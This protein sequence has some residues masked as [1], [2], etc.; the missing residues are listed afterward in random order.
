MIS[1]ATD[2]D[3]CAWFCRRPTAS[4]KGGAWCSWSMTN[5][6]LLFF[7]TCGLTMWC[8]SIVALMAMKSAVHVY[9]IEHPNNTK[10][11]CGASTGD[12]CWDG[13]GFLHLNIVDYLNARLALLGLG[14]LP[15]VA[16]AAWRV[17]GWCEHNTFSYQEA[18]N[19]I[20]EYKKSE[21]GKQYHHHTK[22]KE[23]TG[24]P[25]F[26]YCGMGFQTVAGISIFNLLAVFALV[27]DIVAMKQWN[28]ADCKKAVNDLEQPWF[29]PEMHIDWSQLPVILFCT[30]LL[31]M[32]MGIFTC[33][34]GFSH[35]CDFMTRQAKRLDREGNEKGR[36]ES[37]HGHATHHQSNMQ[38]SS[39]QPSAPPGD[40]VTGAAQFSYNYAIP[41][42]GARMFPSQHQYQ[43]VP[44]Y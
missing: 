19:K 12:T 30:N 11:F 24:E 18:V 14:I 2:N 13:S 25:A 17:L 15:A 23:N 38:A 44:I 32:V 21:Y 34:F 29:D 22:K 40:T 20:D 41:I 16:W 42:T 36:S 37:H 5:G 28:G 35:A 9:N 31:A 10:K 6:V 39:G 33:V 26:E 3:W 4:Q 1:A 7:G 27:I 8:L 43:A